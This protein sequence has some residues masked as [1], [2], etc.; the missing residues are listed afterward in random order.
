MALEVPLD[1]F[2]MGGVVDKYF[3]QK[4]ARYWAVWTN[5]GAR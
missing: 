2:W 4:G 5:A 1:Q 3:N